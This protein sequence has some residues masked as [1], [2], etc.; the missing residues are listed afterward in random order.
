MWIQF[1]AWK[2]KKSPFGQYLQTFW[3]MTTY[4]RLCPRS[5]QNRPVFIDSPDIVLNCDKTWYILVVLSN[6]ATKTAVAV[7]GHEIKIKKN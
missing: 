1:F 4:A 7:K 3:S 6:K 5:L 2:K